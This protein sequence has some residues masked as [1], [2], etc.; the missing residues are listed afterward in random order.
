[1][2]NGTERELSMLEGIDMVSFLFWNLNNNRS[3]NA[4]VKIVK[5]HEIDIIILC[6]W[7]CSSVDLLA[8]LNVIDPDFYP[9]F[10]LTK[11][12]KIF[13]KF[14]NTFIKPIYENRRLTI[15]HISL[16]LRKDILLAVVHFPDMRNH[17]PDSQFAES[18]NLGNTIREQERK[19]GH[20]RTV[21]VGDLNMNPFDPGVVAAN[22]LHAVMTRSVADKGSRIVQETKYPFFYNPMW[23]LFGDGTRCTPGTYYYYHSEQVTF[24]WNMFDQVLI[25]PELLDR[26]NIH[27]VQ[28]IDSDGEASLL[29]SDGAPNRTISDHLPISFKINL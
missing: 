16:P 29:S 5:K 21:L 19:I 10:G 26:F 13:T 7:K 3:E 25:R 27:D 20:S 2:K 24:F 15:R 28:I 9:T 12:I 6:E 17:K 8:K 18:I 4:I 22:G 11:K 1:M 14:S 23:S